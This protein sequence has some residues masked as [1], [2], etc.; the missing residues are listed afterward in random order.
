MNVV[1]GSFVSADAALEESV[2]AEQ[3]SLEGRFTDILYSCIWLFV[4]ETWDVIDAGIK[5][6]EL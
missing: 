6:I 2:R 4:I 3:S 5:F 1:P